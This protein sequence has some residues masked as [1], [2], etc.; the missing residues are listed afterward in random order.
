[1]VAAVAAEEPE[2]AANIP[3]LSIFTCSSLPGSLDKIG[4][5]PWNKS[6]DRRVRNRISPIQMNNGRAVNDQE[7]VALQEEVPSN[8][9][10]LEFSIKINP[11]MA[12]PVSVSEIHMPLTSINSIEMA[13]IALITDMSICYSSLA[14]SSSF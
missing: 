4:A 12:K 3:Q 6:S 1:M 5:S 10:M 8:K 13:R 2:T 11:R 7:V 9:P 14:S